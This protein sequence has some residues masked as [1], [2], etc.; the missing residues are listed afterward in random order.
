MTD[1]QLDVDLA[2]PPAQ[3]WR[4]LTD[5]R[6]LTEWWL[7][8]DLAA[9]AGETF[10]VLPPPGTAGLP[11]PFDIDVL[12]VQEPSVLLQRWSGDDLHTQ[13]SWEI[14]ERPGGSRLRFS[15][16]GYFGLDGTERRGELR[17]LYERMFT[18][19]LPAVLSRLDDGSTDAGGAVGEAQAAIPS[20]PGA[21]LA[22]GQLDWTVEAGPDSSN[23]RVRLLSLI[24]AAVLVVL[25]S[26]AVAVFSQGE[27]PLP[28]RPVAQQGHG[29]GAGE[30]E[31]NPHGVQA[32]GS[33]GARRTSGGTGS[34]VTGTPDPA[35]SG[36]VP[37]G[38]ESSPLPAD[39]TALTASHKTIALL[40]L[41]GFDTEVT[42]RNPGPASA[43]GWTV[44][45]VM[46]SDKAVE[47][48]T[49]N[50]AAVTQ[51]ADVVTLTATAASRELAANATITLVVRYP[52]LLALGQAAKSC[53]IDGRA[54]A[55]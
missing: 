30:Q 18:V 24:G 9:E 14:T 22:G 36:S 55:G 34:T 42:V 2:Y 43:Q 32:S 21:G 35:A 8:T 44:V 50:L 53:T 27:G 54:C 15:Q 16:H 25:V 7:P 3:V 51:S 28:G 17:D 29:L 19:R 41:G 46:P 52:A 5:R 20:R 40:G 23:R 4:A 13:V 12:Q 47:N 48:R 11:A 26:S 45:L 37:P 1:L 10:Q 49:P 31:G 38:T 33:P 39:P 6:L